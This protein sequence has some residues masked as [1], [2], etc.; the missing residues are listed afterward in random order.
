[1]INLNKIIGRTPKE[2]W[3]MFD[4]DVMRQIQYFEHRMSPNSG[5]P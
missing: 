5:R 3:E 1:M 2:I 4:D